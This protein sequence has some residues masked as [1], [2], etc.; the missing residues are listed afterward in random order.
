MKHKQIR[1]FYYNALMIKD[2]TPDPKLFITLNLKAE[3]VKRLNIKSYCISLKNICQIQYSRIFYQKD[4]H[5]HES[6]AC[7]KSWD[8][9]AIRGK[10]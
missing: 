1:S 7:L 4:C 10:N 8:L 2:L 9:I 6:W 3:S 5:Y